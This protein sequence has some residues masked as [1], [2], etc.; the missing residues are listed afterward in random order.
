MA[1]NS[2]NVSQPRAP[3][4]YPGLQAY[5]GALR[6]II[7]GFML[8]ILP[9]IKAACRNPETFYFSWLV[10]TLIVPVKS[11]CCQHQ[12]K[13]IQTMALY[14]KIGLDHEH[15]LD[16]VQRWPPDLTGKHLPFLGNNPNMAAAEWY[17]TKGWNGQ[18]HSKQGFFFRPSPTLLSSHLPLLFYFSAILE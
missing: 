3:A 9:V 8:G 2:A 5:N 15:G 12:Q 6:S 4:T 7:S 10:I 18:F 14:L 13:Q 16:Y 1:G 11:R 17:M